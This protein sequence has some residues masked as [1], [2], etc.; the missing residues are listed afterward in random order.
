[1]NT[2]GFFERT[3]HSRYENIPKT[4]YLLVQYSFNFDKISTLEKFKNDRNYLTIPI[5]EWRPLKK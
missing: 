5:S 2:Q 1:M 3:L 4:L